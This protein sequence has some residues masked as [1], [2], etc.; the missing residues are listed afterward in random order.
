MATIVYAYPF[1]WGD[2]EANSKHIIECAKSKRRSPGDVLV[3]AMHAMTGAV[4]TFES[5][6]SETKAA[7]ESAIGKIAKAIKKTGV[8]VVLPAMVTRG[9]G[10]HLLE[11]GTVSVLPMFETVGGLVV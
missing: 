3:F 5:L 11:N 10:V 8:K 6:P 1:V 9:M 4:H 2:I 7:I